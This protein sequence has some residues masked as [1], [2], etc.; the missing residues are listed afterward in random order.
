MSN[1]YY[2]SR[3]SKLKRKKRK[4]TSPIAKILITTFLLALFIYLIFNCSNIFS[5]KAY[6]DPLP[7][8]SNNNTVTEATGTGAIFQNYKANN[9][10]TVSGY[11]KEQAHLL[12][13]IERT[14]INTTLSMNYYDI[15]NLYPDSLNSANAFENNF[16]KYSNIL[17]YS[18]KAAE[19][20]LVSEIYNANI[21]LINSIVSYNKL[22]NSNS[23][24]ENVIESSK[25]TVQNNFQTLTNLI[26]NNI[27][28]F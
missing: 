5:A 20:P 1:N 15:V 7:N 21:S 25:N 18:K 3:T 16:L 4:N 19:E 26:N 28:L 23:A 6:A 17:P 22:I 10:N 11:M 13:N 8:Q 27:N 2:K 9:L 14:D 24:T 12:N